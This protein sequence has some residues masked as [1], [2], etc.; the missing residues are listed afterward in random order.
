VSAPSARNTTYEET[1][2]HIASEMQVWVRVAAARDYNG[3]WQ[4]RLAELASGDAPP[5]WDKRDWVYPE[6]VFSG[7]VSDGP[8]VAGWLRANEL[9]VCGR[10]LPTPQLNSG[11]AT[12]ERRQSFSSA[13]YETFSWPVTEAALSSAG[14]GGEPQGHLIGEEGAPS[15]LSFYVAAANFFWLDRQPA[16]GSLN[17]GIVYRHQDTRG[18]INRVRVTTDAVEVE[19]EG[20]GLSG[21][22]VELPGDVPGPLQAIVLS[23]D[24]GAAYKATFGFDRGLPPGTWVLL[25]KGPE[26]VDRRFLSVPW[27]RGKE[28]G[29]EV[30]VDGATRL[31]ALVGGRE[32][33][34]VEFKR[35]VPK[36]DEDKR[37]VMKSVC[38]FA[39]GHGGSLLVGVD[40]D[41]ELVGLEPQAIDR[42][43]DQLTQIVSSWVDPRPA[44][45]FEV[46]PVPDSNRVVL[47]M[48][49]QPGSVLYG[50]GRPGETRVPYVRYH[51]TCERASTHEITNIVQAR[52]SVPSKYSMFLGK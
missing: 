26:W 18:R 36:A 50:C 34:Q 17:Q 35:Q 10:L 40:D 16:G 11:T 41:R 33:D 28:A 1:L 29:V 47:E 32:R 37:Q 25:R 30:A 15:F 20:N 39:N 8:T 7:Y 27:T 2:E 3:S 42:L 48:Q 6:A 22:S 38:A 24:H 52:S 5:S 49:V 13:V 45:D 43:K 14:Q 51:G 9:E 44:I 31:E 46:L 21:M 23:P 4:V 12:W 19:L